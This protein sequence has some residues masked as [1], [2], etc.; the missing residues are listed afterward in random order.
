[1]R[2]HPELRHQEREA[3]PGS[4]VHQLRITLNSFHVHRIFSVCVNRSRFFGKAGDYIFRGKR[5]IL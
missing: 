5:N 3:Q 4:A 1:M 2:V